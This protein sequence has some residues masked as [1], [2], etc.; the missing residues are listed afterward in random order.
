M[1]KI[2]VGCDLDDTL[3]DFVGMLLTHYNADYNDNLT[4][5]DIKGWATHK[6]IKSEGK[7]IFKYANWVSLTRLQIPAKTKETLIGLMEDNDIDLK[8]VTACK[9]EGLSYRKKALL[10]NL[11]DCFVS[12]KQLDK[13]LFCMPDKSLFAG[14]FLIDDCH[15]NVSDG[16]YCG[17]LINKPWNKECKYPNFLRADDLTEAINKI[18]DIMELRGKVN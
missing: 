7:D 1:K 15:D 2:I 11:G 9:P 12:E 14:D 3:W 13:M 18:K 4:K 16:K 17:I 6:Y 5:D 10:N 8:F